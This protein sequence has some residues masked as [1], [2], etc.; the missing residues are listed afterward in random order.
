MKKIEIK[1][2]QASVAPLLDFIKS[3]SDRLGDQLM[4]DP[5]LLGMEPDL[6]ETWREDL[7]ESLGNDGK[8][9]MGLFGSRFFETGTI[10]IDLENAEAVLRAGSAL[11]LRLRESAL[12]RFTDEVLENG[13]WDLEEMTVEEQKGYSCYL[14]LAAIQEVII[15][16]L[17][18]TQGS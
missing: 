15:D 5:R 9:F 13:D 7:L 16:H 1:L 17:G 6:Q 3:L 18:L 10:E 14:F 8:V 12:K 2:S 4:I 11:R